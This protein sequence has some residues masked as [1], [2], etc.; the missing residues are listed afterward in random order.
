MST[1]GPLRLSTGAPQSNAPA[2]H[3]VQKMSKEYYVKVPK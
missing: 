1:G 3:G 2:D